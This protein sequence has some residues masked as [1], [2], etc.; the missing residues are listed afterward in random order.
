MKLLKKSKELIVISIK[1]D[2]D[3]II[4][5]KNLMIVIKHN[6]IGVSIDYYRN[7]KDTPFREDQVEFTD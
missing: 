5:A 6:D 2:N 4:Y 3:V 1:E 7:R